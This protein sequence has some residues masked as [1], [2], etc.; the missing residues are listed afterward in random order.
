MSYTLALERSSPPGSL[1]L[2]DGRR[3]VEL[4]ACE[5]A[6]LR[7]PEWVAAL[8]SELAAAG[9]APAALE[10][11]IVGLGPG[12][13]SGIR[14]ALAAA[15]G[16]ALPRDIPVMG[17]SSVAALARRVALTQ[18]AANVAVIGD[19]RRRRF[20]LASYHLEPGGRLLLAATGAPP[21]HTSADFSLHDCEELT[22]LLPAGVPVVALEGARLAAELERRGVAIALL[23]EMSP[24]TA[25]D[26]LELWLAD[27]AATRRDPLPVYLHPAV[28]A[29]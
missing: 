24:A 26:L 5:S 27:P 1:A 28:A 29:A 12:S 16:L 11:L 15:Q 6:T 4:P 22:R 20:W 3:V 2:H 19:A 17:L 23:P 13:F 10:R 14:A 9:V 25:T 18:A 8:G 21:A 7:A